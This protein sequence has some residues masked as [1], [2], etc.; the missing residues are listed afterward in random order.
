MK[1]S[2][3]QISAVEHLYRDAC[4]F[5]SVRFLYIKNIHL[6]KCLTFRVHITSD[7]QLYNV[8]FGM[9]LQ[10]VR[11]YAS[12]YLC[13]VRLTAE[14]LGGQF[15]DRYVVECLFTVFV[16]ACSCVLVHYRI[17]ACKLFYAVYNVYR[18]FAGDTFIGGGETA[19]SVTL[20]YL[21]YFV[22]LECGIVVGF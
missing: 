10:N 4:H 6:Q 9:T 11:V 1:A 12:V 19:G 14:L 18:A 5:F 22:D 20:D 21:A 16:L 13:F 2:C 17:K 8:R 15:E 3:F 7:V